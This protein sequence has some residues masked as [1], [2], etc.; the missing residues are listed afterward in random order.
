MR[1]QTE[2][3]THFHIFVSY[4]MGYKEIDRHS[5]PSLIII[6]NNSSS[7]RLQWSGKQM[8]I[9]ILNC[10]IIIGALFWYEIFPESCKDITPVP[11]D[12]EST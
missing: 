2:N 10:D 4:S 11:A 8:V 1:W 9:I 5:I 6:S 12:P 3:I 7:F